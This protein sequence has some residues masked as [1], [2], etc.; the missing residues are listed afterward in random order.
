M[1]L[2]TDL[3][4]PPNQAINFFIVGHMDDLLAF[5]ADPNCPQCLLRTE[6]FHSYWMC[7]QCGLALLTPPVW[8]KEDSGEA[9]LIL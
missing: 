7:L 2:S 4:Q 6:W 8:P 9:D 1:N 3:V 5:W